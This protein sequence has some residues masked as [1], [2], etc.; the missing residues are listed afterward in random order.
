MDSV[1]RYRRVGN[2][3]QGDNVFEVQHAVSRMSSKITVR[4]F[5]IDGCISGLTA[6]T[7][8]SMTSPKKEKEEDG[9]T[10][11][12][13][14]MTSP[15]TSRMSTR[16]GSERRRRKQQADIR[17]V[18]KNTFLD[19]LDDA[20]IDGSPK[21]EDEDDE[22]EEEEED[23]STPPMTLRMSITGE[24]NNK[25]RKEERLKLKKYVHVFPIHVSKSEE[26]EIRG[27]IIGTGGA[28]MKFIV[29][30]CPSAKIRIRGREKTLPMRVFL[31]CS[32]LNEF[33]AAKGHVEALLSGI[34]VR[35]TRSEHA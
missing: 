10:R 17:Y 9:L 1:T 26:R 6:S 4:S 5:D 31:S 11:E 33:E 12:H 30:L 28:N 3:T 25:K 23:E 20:D 21:K 32:S 35:I 24:I 19:T 22:E 34:F 7:I 13:M 18:R 2:K 27:G 8:D 14:R 15:M 16:G 29:K